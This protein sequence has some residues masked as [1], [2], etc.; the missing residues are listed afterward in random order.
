MLPQARGRLARAAWRALPV[1]VA[2]YGAAAVLAMSL[3]DRLIFVPPPPSCGPGLEGLVT[4]RTAEGGE[5][6]AR[7]IPA[8]GGSQGRT[9]ASA[10]GEPSAAADDPAD[11]GPGVTHVLFAHGNAE[12]LGHLDDLAH[13]YAELGVTVL[14]FDYPGYGMSRGRPTE[15]GAYR[16]ADA[17]LTYLVEERGADPGRI[18]LHGRS[19]GG[20]VMIELAA[21]HRVGA[22]VVESSFVSAFRVVTRLPLLPFDRFRSL[23]KL[24]RVEAPVLVI[25]GLRDEVVAP[26][27]GRRIF[28]EIPPERRAALWVEEAGHNDLVWTAGERYWEALEAFLESVGGMDG[29]GGDSAAV[30]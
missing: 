12:D 19:L 15:G 16:A 29:G 14:V 28:A 6:A 30:R 23:A 24:S 25:H 18:V 3:A 4:L 17:A 21:R 26:W 9:R 10:A 8:P 20:A 1:A 5:V 27:H 7:L 13:R 22:L 2:A 11:Q